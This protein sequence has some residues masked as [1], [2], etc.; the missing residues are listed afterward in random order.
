MFARSGG[1]AASAMLRVAVLRTRSGPAAAHAVGDVSAAPAWR[2]TRRL[3]TS[4]GAASWIRYRLA[5]AGNAA[6][7]IDD[8]YIDPWAKH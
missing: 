8:L 5:P 7:S 1:G 2:A 4:V 3:A 6:V